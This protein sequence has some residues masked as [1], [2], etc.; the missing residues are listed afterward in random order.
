MKRMTMLFLILVASFSAIFAEND[1]FM[2]AGSGINPTDVP[3]K[4]TVGKK[5]WSAVL[6]TKEELGQAKTIT[7]LGLNAAFDIGQEFSIYE[8]KVFMKHTDLDKFESASMYGF[9]NPA[10]VGSTFEQVLTLDSLTFE[11]KG[12][13]VLDINDFDYNGN[14]NLIVYFESKN[15]TTSGSLKFM[16]KVVPYGSG[17]AIAASSDYTIPTSEEGHEAEPASLP[18]MRFYYDDEGAE[19]AYDPSPYSGKVKASI[20]P[21]F[22][23]YLGDNAATYDLYLGS[24]IDAM[25]LVADGESAVGGLNSYVSSSTLEQNT[26][27][28]WKVVVK[29]ASGNVTEGNVWDFITE[30]IIVVDMD[31]PY[32]EGFEST[33]GY[34]TPWPMENWED[35]CGVFYG[36]RKHDDDH[37]GNA[38]NNAHTGK[39][40][41]MAHSNYYNKDDKALL[42][43]PTFQ[44]PGNS[45]ISFYWC[46]NEYVPI[47]NSKGKVKDNS[48]AIMPDT[49]YFEISN[50]GGESWTVLAQLNEEADTMQDYRKEEVLLGDYANQKVMFR[51]RYVVEDMEFGHYGYET[52]LDDIE[53]I[54]TDLGSQLNIANDDVVFDA[55][56]NTTESVVKVGIKNVGGAP[57]TISSFAVEAPF[58]VET[59]NI[60]LAPEA[61]DTVLVKFNP[62]TIGDFTGTLTFT[63]DG[64]GETEI[65]LSGTSFGRIDSFE[66]SFDTQQTLPDAWSSIILKDEA[67][68]SNVYVNGITIDS[69]SDPYHVKLYNSTDT[70]ATLMLVT[71][72]MKNFTGKMLTFWLKKSYVEQQNTLEIGVMGN[73]N[74]VSSFEEVHTISS[75]MTAEYEKYSIAIPEVD[76]KPYIA[77]NFADHVGQF[78]SIYLDDISFRTDVFEVPPATNT[79]QPLN[80]GYNTLISTIL[81][82]EVGQSATQGYKL[83]IGTDNPPTNIENGLVIDDAYNTMYEFAA[84]LDYSKRYYWKVVPFNSIGDAVDCPI[85]SFQTGADPVVTVGEGEP[86]NENYDT[87]SNGYLPELEGWTVEDYAGFQLFDWLVF[88]QNGLAYSAPGWNDHIGQS[89]ASPIEL[90]GTTFQ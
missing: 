2:E 84:E 80:N 50:N 25:T 13:L 19:T 47:L 4:A 60:V 48:R 85:W 41:A 10:G 74:D 28:F 29:D 42:T 22:K 45:Q 89:T 81:K 18:N 62:Q 65:P 51:W 14:E 52:Y 11:N 73:P 86:Y 24:A 49:T 9:S 26:E 56:A 55:I 87:Y 5:T 82:W 32:F 59:R 79:L 70:T 34:T 17:R 75:A 44:L 3:F 46:D 37:W 53:I 76:G 16:S 43:S 71:P 30:S 20:N 40:C 27:Y 12:F 54:A 31:N 39:V 64:A 58:A 66:E 36:W 8:Q 68:I 63:H 35:N 88:N 77:F 72:A 61:V 15:D 38:Y 57:L 33:A 23:F 6:Y 83:Y 1:Q 67:D 21:N 7:K 90:K 69:H 78:N